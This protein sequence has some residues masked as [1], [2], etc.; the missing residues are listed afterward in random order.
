MRDGTKLLFV[1]LALLFVGAIPTMADVATSSL[2]TGNSDISG[3]PGPYGSVMIDLTSGTM[4]TITFTADAG[5]LFGGVN[6]VDANINAASWT[7]SGLTGTQ[8]PGF[9]KGVL[10]TDTG[11]GNVDGFGGLNQTF[12]EFDGFTWALNSVS[13]IVTDISGTWANAASVLAANGSGFDA[14][15]HIFVC[16]NGSTAQ[17]PCVPGN[18]ALVT[19]FAA[20]SAGSVKGIVP[21]PSSYLLLGTGMLA[22]AGLYKKLT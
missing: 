13:F 1:L 22:L 5:F 21:E 8:L 11:S 17:G 19:G 3:I 18:G 16:G 9:T 4:A 10:L 15:A 6:V 12:S 2:D 14:G 7:I 20:E